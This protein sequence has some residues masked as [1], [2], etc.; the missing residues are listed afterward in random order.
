MTEL[1]DDDIRRLELALEEALASQRTSSAR[2]VIPT[3]PTNNMEVEQI[4]SVDGSHIEIES[5]EKALETEL[6][7]R[8]SVTIIGITENTCSIGINLEEIGESGIIDS[9]DLVN[10]KPQYHVNMIN[11]GEQWTVAPCDLIKNDDSTKI[12]LE[13][14]LN[15]D[16]EDAKRIVKDTFEDRVVINETSTILDFI[17]HFPEINIT[18][19]IGHKHKIIDLYIVFEFNK[20][21]SL[22]TIV[23]AR[24]RFRG[25][26]TTQTVSEYQKSY[27]HSHLPSNRLIGREV[28][29]AE[30]CLGTAQPLGES[31]AKLMYKFD[32]NVF[33][34]CCWQLEPFLSWESLEGGPYVRIEHI[35]DIGN[36]RA[37][38]D[39][40]IELYDGFH[41][42]IWKDY[43]RLEYEI[44]QDCG[45]NILK[46]TYKSMENLL[47]RV[48]KSDTWFLY[49]NEANTYFKKNAS[50][51]PFDLESAIRT[52]P[53]RVYNGQS[54]QCKILSNFATEREL[55]KVIHPKLIEN[56]AAYLTNLIN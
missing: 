5:K 3:M 28:P 20:K 25:Y 29:I 13:E 32:A 15:K 16:I 35:K 1:D 46:P 17:I 2:Q 34:S 42:Y 50:A 11:S 44:K 53:S 23:P 56:T 9:I 36:Y 54:V 31:W 7:E 43:D 26:R 8:D 21:L 41:N 24:R 55:E 10:G 48:G 39:R 12:K 18:N 19:T 22:G 45:V 14:S 51:D 37:L 30:F 38:T 47:F 40:D 49:K 52:L 6:K 33:M 27:F 4:I